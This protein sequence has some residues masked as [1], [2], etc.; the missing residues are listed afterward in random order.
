MNKLDKIKFLQQFISPSQ[1]L[2]IVA[3]T[4]GEEKQFFND[5]IDEVI[6]TI[7]GMPSTGQ[8][9]GS[10]DAAIVY[11]HYFAGGADWYITEKDKGSSDDA[12]EDKGKQFQA[13]G[14]ADLFH[15]GGELG[16]ISIQELIEN[17]IELDLHFRPQTLA[18][19]KESL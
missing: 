9:D 14:L 3:G 5:K 2:C 7:E 18:E 4:R 16:Y 15:D 6:K 12:P 1:L 19:V 11:L 8:T 17:N 13:F 10:G